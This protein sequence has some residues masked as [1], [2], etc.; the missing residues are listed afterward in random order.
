MIV[1]AAGLYVLGAVLAV[2]V[3]SAIDTVGNP[4]WT[5]VWV[6]TL[7][8]FIAVFCLAWLAVGA[9]STMVSTLVATWGALR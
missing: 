7:W 9:A 2:L 6:A 4:T 5:H 1:L 8:P 3:L